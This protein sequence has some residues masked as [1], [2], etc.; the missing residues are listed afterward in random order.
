MTTLF[1]PRK[2]SVGQCEVPLLKNEWMGKA[3]QH[4]MLLSL[5]SPPVSVSDIFSNPGQTAQPFCLS[6]FFFFSISFS[7]F[8]FSCEVSAVV[9]P[10]LRQQ[11]AIYKHVLIRVSVKVR[12]SKFRVMMYMAGI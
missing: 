12:S 9:S 5:F 6:L 7:F 3:E 8:F 11:E 2:V 10:C 1:M 4:D